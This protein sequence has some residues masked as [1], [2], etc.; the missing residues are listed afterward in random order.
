MKWSEQAF[1]TCGWD[2]GTQGF[3]MHTVSGYVS[4][5]GRFGIYQGWHGSDWLLIHRASG[6]QI[7][8]NTLL[9]NVKWAAG[10][11]DGCDWNFRSQWSRKLK[12][13]YPVV[14]RVEVEMTRRNRRAR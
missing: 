13:L 4:D 5:C 9:A 3:E 7:L 14:K 8:S 2:G 6:G 1:Q 10:E 11:M 12:E